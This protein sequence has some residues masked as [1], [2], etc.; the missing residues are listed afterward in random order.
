MKTFQDYLE[1]VKATNEALDP[2][3][4]GAVIGFTGS[5]LAT[6][7]SSAVFKAKG[8]DNIYNEIARLYREFKD[9]KQ[10]KK[11]I[12]D[13]EY[14]NKLLKILDDAFNSTDNTGKKSYISKVRNSIKK[15]IETKD[16]SVIAHISKE[17]TDK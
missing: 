13:E 8:L 3:A 1:E 16:P 7:I 12:N 4:T 10:S 6:L 11:I 2:Y 14:R 15:A 17:F 9:K 5:L